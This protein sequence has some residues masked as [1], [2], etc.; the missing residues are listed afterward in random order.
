LWFRCETTDADVVT[1]CS[2]AVLSAVDTAV[3]V[4]RLNAVDM[5]ARTRSPA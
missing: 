3:R 1:P 2:V 5:I 4:N